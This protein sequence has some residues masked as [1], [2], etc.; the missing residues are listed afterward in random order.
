MARWLILIGLVIVAVGLTLQYAPS[1]L[2]WFGRLPG[3]VRIETDRGRIFFPITSMLI[4]SGVL[5]L[6]IHLF[7]R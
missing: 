6:L 2:N 3:D 1:L 7:R 5:S 4:V